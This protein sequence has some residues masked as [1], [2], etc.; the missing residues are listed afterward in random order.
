MAMQ[1]SSVLLQR[2]TLIL[3]LTRVYAHVKNRKL[4]LVEEQN[5]N[6]YLKVSSSDSTASYTMQ[7]RINK[8]IKH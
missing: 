7:K 6:Y 3:Y 4:I 2:V 8:L 5:H 1:S